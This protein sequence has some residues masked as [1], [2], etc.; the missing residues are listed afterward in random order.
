MKEYA[1]K[2]LGEPIPI[3]AQLFK[4]KFGSAGYIYHNIKEELKNLLIEVKDENSVSIEID[5]WKRMIEAL[6]GYKPPLSLFIDH[7]YL[8]ILAK[9]IIYLGFN[10]NDFDKD[11]TN[12]IINGNYFVNKDI[13]NFL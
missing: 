2:F 4:E 5:N 1:S 13:K 6:Y 9:I 3:S 7:T 11:R 12:D 10:D 8:S